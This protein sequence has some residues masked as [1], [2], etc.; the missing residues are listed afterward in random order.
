MGTQILHDHSLSL[1]LDI[2]VFIDAI[3][4]ILGTDVGGHDQNGVLEVHGLAGGIGDT[5]IV[6]YLKQDI[7][8]IRMCLFHLIEENNRVRFSADCLG[9]LTTLIVADISRRCSDQAGYRMFL[10]VLT[11]IDTDHIVLIVEQCLSQGFRKLSL[12]DTGRSKEQ[13]GTNRFGRIL[14]P[15]FG[16]KDGFSYLF[17]AFIL[18]YD[19]FVQH[20]IQMQDLAA[21][22]L[23]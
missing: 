20:G 21:L 8:Y 2:A 1:R 12:A 3:Q 7:E 13:E 4:Q 19:P 17:H 11:H 18:A 10:H 6:Q 14:D 22:A 15:G 23:V 9:Q 16:T 5:T